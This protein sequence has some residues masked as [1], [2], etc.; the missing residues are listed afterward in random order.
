[1]SLLPFLLQGVIFSLNLA[2]LLIVLSCSISAL[3]PVH[4]S[5][6][7]SQISDI[8]QTLSTDDRAVLH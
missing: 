8:H 1:M 2:K 6:S 4:L 3:K 5:Y 7:M